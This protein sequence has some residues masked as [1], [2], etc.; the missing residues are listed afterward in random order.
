[1]QIA[2]STRSL[3]GT[4]PQA[5]QRAAELGFQTVELNLVSDEFAYGY[6]R[7]P[8]VQF[9]RELR[10]QIDAL[11]L[12]IWSVTLP[13][14]TQEQ[15]FGK[16]ARRDVLLNA[17]GAAGVLGA[18][19]LVIDPAHLF[20][21]EDAYEAY[22]ADGLAPPIADGY[23]ELWAQVV[24]R[25]M[26]VALRNV[27]YWVGSVL[28]N[29]PARMRKV[30]FDLGI[31][32]AADVPRAVQRGGLDGW[33]EEVGERAAV[34]YAYDWAEDET[35][36]LTPEDESW[37][38]WLPLLQRTRLKCIVLHGHPNQDAEE[39]VASRDYIADLLLRIPEDAH[40]G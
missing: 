20:S 5:L 40:D 1:M 23:D 31:G 32:W 14:L 13:P 3:G 8:A 7:K 17:A 25:R 2:I 9:Y 33:L 37:Q 29:N 30:T 10:Q 28:T 24:N 38:G 19:V 15:M 21:S 35:T 22:I 26:T 27:N 16:R 12:S 34:A 39:F 36:Q 6:R 4:T 11:Q 18:R